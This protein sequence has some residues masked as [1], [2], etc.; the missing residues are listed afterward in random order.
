MKSATQSCINAVK[1]I[2]SNSS[3]QTEKQ[4]GANP[5][6]PLQPNM[7]KV[8]VVPKTKVR[9]NPTHRFCNQ[10]SGSCFGQLK[11]EDR[12]RRRAL[13]AREN[14]KVTE[15][16]SIIGYFSLMSDDGFSDDERTITSPCMTGHR[17]WGIFPAAGANKPHP[18][19]KINKE[20][21]CLRPA[22]WGNKK[23]VGDMMPHTLRW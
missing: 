12:E 1:S 15:S 4:V 16:M 23:H 10:T 17:I 5:T 6:K 18:N 14:T 22:H 2:H 13:S 9:A 21:R 7:R 8:G 20:L 11:G 3:V 19:K